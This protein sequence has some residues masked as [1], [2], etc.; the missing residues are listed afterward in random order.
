MNI[1]KALKIINLV[2]HILV[3]VVTMVVVFSVLEI[4]RFGVS[5]DAEMEWNI[6][7]SVSC[8]G[9][10][11]TLFLVID[12]INKWTDKLIKQIKSLKEVR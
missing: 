10:L 7:L 6:F 4:F 3:F 8:F 9:A 2:T 5:N 11:I 1:D 12:F